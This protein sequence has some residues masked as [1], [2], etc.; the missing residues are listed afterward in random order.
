MAE[1]VDI[2]PSFAVAPQLGAEDFA[3]LARRSVV[4]VIN[5]RPDNEAGV[6]VPSEVAQRL[7][8]E[9]G[10]HYRYLPTDMAHVLAP[11]MIDAMDE[12]LRS[13]PGR[14]VAYCKSGTRSAILWGAVSVRYRPVDEVL[15][16]L[17]A[18]GF[19]LQA[20]RGEFEAEAAR[21]RGRRAE[22]ANRA[23]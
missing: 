2:T 12:A 10:Q 23:A 21:F 22:A 3:A 15:A 1:I 6:V 13:A 14:T 19:D 20:L 16:T 5:N 7:A 9:A 18:A 17:R 4:H 8:R 11:D